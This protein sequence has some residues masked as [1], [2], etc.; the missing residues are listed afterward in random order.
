MQS[1]DLKLEQLRQKLSPV[2]RLAWM[3]I[4]QEGDGIL[5]ASKFAGKPWL[6]AEEQWPICP[7]C[8][9][10]LQFFLQL[11]LDKLPDK[12]K[13]KFGNGLLQFFCC[14]NKKTECAYEAWQ[15]F[16]ETYLLRIV[17]PDN[18]TPNLETIPEDSF[19]AKLIVGWE[20]IDDYPSLDEEDPELTQGIT[21][22]KEERDLFYENLMYLDRDKLAGW[23]QWIQYHQ[24][25][26]CPTCNQP[27]NQF[28]F[29]IDSEDNIPYMWG[30]VG[31][32]YMI[33]CPTHK[34]QLA[35]LWQ[36]S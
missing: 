11:N 8:H 2:K 27:M 33:Q 24:Y 22:E 21:M 35:F 15:P 13:G 23:P 26:N 31:I 3:P 10:K 5:T 4:V 19:P 16:A 12:L 14:I 29:E 1:N 7:N 36:C 32:G 28:V 34:E 25:P 9:K 17:Q 18:N 30:D 20:E 6:R